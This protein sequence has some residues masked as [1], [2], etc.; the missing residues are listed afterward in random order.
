MGYIGA[1]LM[2]EV[3]PMATE[4]TISRRDGGEGHTIFTRSDGEIFHLFEHGDGQASLCHNDKTPKG[5]NAGI[6]IPNKFVWA[7]KLI[8]DYPTGW[9]V[10]SR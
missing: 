7:E 4:F 6:S 10:Y 2:V 9:P 5:I 8:L 3:A 1:A